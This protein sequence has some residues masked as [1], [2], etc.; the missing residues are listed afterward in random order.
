[1]RDET[2]LTKIAKVAN[3]ILLTI[4]SVYFIIV[5]IGKITEFKTVNN[6]YIEKVYSTDE[7]DN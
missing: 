1:M 6:Y 4:L 2:K 3:I 5:I 7:Q